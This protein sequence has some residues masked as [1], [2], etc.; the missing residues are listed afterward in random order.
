MRMWNVNPKL[1]CR[2]HLLGEHLEAHMFIG[3]IKRNKSL[4]GYINKGLVEVHNIIKRHNILV[5]EMNDRGY[6]HKTPIH[7]IKLYAAGNVDVQSNLRELV[8]RCP[9]C[10]TRQIGGA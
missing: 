9:D 4:K 1:M 5:G 7:N 6:K 3:C 2:R 10:K 8:R